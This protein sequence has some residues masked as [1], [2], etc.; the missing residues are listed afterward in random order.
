MLCK[1]S[2]YFLKNKLIVDFFLVLLVLFILK[3]ETSFEADK[4][5]IIKMASSVPSGSHWHDLLKEMANEWLEI[6]DG[7]VEIRIYPGGV[8]GSE[9]DIVRKMRIGQIHAAAVSIGALS[10][11]DPGVNVLMIPMA[12]DSWD[13]YDSVKTALTPRI[14]KS[15]DE[16]GFIVLNW[17]FSGWS[18]FFGQDPDASVTSAQKTRM[19]A[20]AGDDRIIELWKEAGFHP[21]PLAETDV[22]TALQ[23]GMINSFRTTGMMALVSQWFAFTPYMIDLPWAPLVGATIINKSVWDNIPDLIRV[24]L[25]NSAEKYGN[26]LQAEMDRLE[27]EAIQEMVKRGLTVITPNKTQIREWRNVMEKAYPKVRGV[28]VP[29]EWFDDVF[30]IVNKVRKTQQQ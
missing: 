30:A 18:R 22:L 11:I 10:R 8:A 27:N 5:I 15:L 26:Q 29:E 9:I 16:K 3:P 13:I 6:S 25:K 20:T 14:E 7:T 28:I 19:F 4:H 24:D 2:Q 1:R 17:G 23:T 21:V 12:I